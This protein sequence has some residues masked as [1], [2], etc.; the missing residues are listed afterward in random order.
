[1]ATAKVAVTLEQET[2]KRLDQLVEKRVFVNRSRA[3]QQALKEKLDRMERGR[4]GRECAK[5]N[6]LF[7][8]ALAEEGCLRRS[9]SGPNTKG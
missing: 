6:P 9:S 1:M 3:I 4:L 2:L 5:L 7:E 8:K